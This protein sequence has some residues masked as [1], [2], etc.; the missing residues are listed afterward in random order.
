[1]KR[2]KPLPAPCQEA[3]DFLGLAEITGWTRAGSTAALV[4]GS[5]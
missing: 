5:P 3:D 4:E 2:L 1:M